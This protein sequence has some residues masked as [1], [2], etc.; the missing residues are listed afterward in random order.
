M[1]KLI[2]SM[3]V[4][5]AIATSSQAAPKVEIT[6]MVGKKIY[7]YS[8][9]SPR[10]DDGKALLGARANIYV[11]DRVSVRLG[12]DG[13]KDN[14][15]EIPGRV[16]AK[17][18]IVRGTFG[19]QYDVASKG[20]VTPYIYGGLGGE[21]I[22]QTNPANNVDSQMFYN[23]G[24]GIK[25]RVNDKV[26]L[27]GELQGI[28]KVED[29]DKDVIGHIG[30]GYK[31]GGQ[32]VKTL[33]DLAAMTPPAAPATVE[34]PVAPAVEEPATTELIVEPLDAKE[35][36]VAEPIKE[37]VSTYDNGE[38]GSCGSDRA[39]ATAGGEVES[40][41]Y[42]QV[43]ALRK[44]STD[45]MISRL[46]KHGFNYVTQDAGDVTRV[47]VGPFSSRSAAR[48]TLRRVKRLK[49]DAFIKY[50]N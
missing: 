21:K 33:Q 15:I 42:I 26:N 45:A 14:P 5:S 50:I 1:K 8:D 49:R 30:V 46:E 38:I 31:F 36:A 41:Y 17:T 7:N 11:K 44:N 18:D 2:S 24:A 4:L 43:I 6:G 25:Y 35:A 34:E 12:V 28:R 22:Y 48:K 47:L 10:F 9:D 29:G 13:S 37:A 27:V 3:V 40:G 23:G 20:R 32:K 16:G 39:T 19:L